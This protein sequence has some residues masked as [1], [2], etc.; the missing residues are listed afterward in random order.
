MNPVNIRLLN[1]QLAAPQFTDPAEVVSFMGAMQAQEYRMMRWAVAMRT[2][3]PSLK[4]FREAYDSGRI[5]RMHLHRGTWQL[6]SGEDYWWML[7]LIRD[8]ADATLAGWMSAN[9]ISLPEKEVT[10]IREILCE[11]AETKGSALKADFAQ[12]LEE[13][14]IHM[15]DHRLSYHIRY[16]ETAGVLC[17]GD[18]HPMK[19]SYSLVSEKLGAPV[20]MDRDE[21]LKLLARKYFQSHQPA[22]LEDYVWWSGLNISDCRKGIA[23]LGDEIHTEV[24]KGYTFYL[25]DSCRTRGARGGHILLPSYDEYLIGYKSRLLVLPEQHT[26]K[27][28]SQNGIFFP[29]ILRDGIVCGNWSP[30]AKGSVMEFFDGVSP[31]SL[32]GEW[33]TYRRYLS[34]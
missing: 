25:M 7:E 6:I 4:A 14:D 34:N 13:R 9:G 22:T 2:K 8:K 5:V 19:P 33:E 18:L 24:W 23:L 17:S 3:K 31:D 21:S 27:A 28:H 15:D 12:A 32:E 29:V 10:E 16:A 30:Y 20:A 26:P 1:Q 11:V